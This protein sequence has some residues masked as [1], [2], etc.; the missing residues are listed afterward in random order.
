MAILSHRQKETKRRPLLFTRSKNIVQVHGAWFSTKLKYFKINISC[1]L[2]VL[3]RHICNVM[4]SNSDNV[5]L[6]TMLS[7]ESDRKCK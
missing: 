3:G 7:E 6:Y 2:D 4:C 1:Q 5:W